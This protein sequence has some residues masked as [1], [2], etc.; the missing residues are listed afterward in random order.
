MKKPNYHILVC[1]S[2]R[3]NGDAQGF[4]NKQGAPSLL[5]YITEE[6]NDRGLD[7]AVSTTGC[8]NLCSQGPILVVQPNNDW[9][10]GVSGEDVIDEILDAIEAGEP[11][12]KYLISE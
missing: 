1:N 4:C 10:G 9:Y 11:C 8:L 3:L 6:C 5:Q 7:V 12:E 2:F